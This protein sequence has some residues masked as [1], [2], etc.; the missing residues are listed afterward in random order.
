MTPTYAKLTEQE[1]REI[2][3]FGVTV[4]GMRE[5]V[6]QS[7]NVYPGHKNPATMVASMLSDAQ[8]EMFFDEDRARQTINRAK[9]ILSEYLSK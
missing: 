8:E 4:Q 5:A 6:E 2:R 7:L 1:K 3:M 9:W